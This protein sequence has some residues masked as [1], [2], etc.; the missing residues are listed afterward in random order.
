[1]LQ[2]LGH[3]L[4]VPGLLG[5]LV[6]LPI[7][8][9]AQIPRWHLD[10][11]P[12]GSPGEEFQPGSWSPDGKRF[13]FSRLDQFIVVRVADGA[14]QW[15][16]FGSWPVWVDDETIDAVRDIGLSRW[17][18]YRLDLSSGRGEALPIT[19]GVGRLVGRGVLDLAAAT[20]T[21]SI[22]TTVLDP[23]SGRQIATIPGVRA[24]GWIRPGLLIGKA[25]D[26]ANQ[27]IGLQPGSL[28]AWTARDGARPIG[29]HLDDVRDV[30]TGSPA[31]DAIACV[32]AR[33]DTGAAQPPIGIYRVPVDGSPPTL[34]ADVVRG[35]ANTDPI[36]SWLDDS[37]VVFLDGAGLHRI[38]PQGTD[39]AIPGIDPSDLPAMGYYGRAYRLGD[40]V[41]VASQLGSGP[42]GQARLTLVGLD[43][44]IQ[45]RHVF[46]SWNGVG[47]IID[48]ARPQAL[49]YTDPREADEPPG[50][51]FVLTRH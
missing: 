43:G 9:L 7:I 24:I 45:S 17:Q 50:R 46:P 36:V 1:M 44:E 39:S 38:T 30:I 19:L 6:L 14:V 13:V 2:R 51:Y 35:D 29:P 22:S 8:L 28:V 11:I 47:M 10:P 23:L 15:T 20:L 40:A 5:I 26:A 32:C 37:S 4:V 27:G 31:G 16:G 34:L 25:V 18:L 21:D 48:S 49:V 41:A 3:P 42:T 33:M 12:M